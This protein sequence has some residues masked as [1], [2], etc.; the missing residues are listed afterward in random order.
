MA[1]LYP[2]LHDRFRTEG[3]CP[4]CLM[5]TDLAPKYVCDNGHMM[6][7]RCKPYYFSCPTCF[8]PMELQ[9]PPGHVD[10]PHMP[11]QTHYTPLPMPRT[12]F[13]H[14]P[15]APPM[16]DFINKERS[17]YPYEPSPDQ[18]LISCSYQSSGCWVKVP[19]HL[20][21]LHESR[22]QFRPHLEVEVLPTDLNHGQ[23]DLIEC[24]YKAA[25]CNVRTPFWR[26]A[27]H[28]E[29]CVFKDKSI[30]LNEITEDLGKFNFL[31]ESSQLQELVICRYRNYGC[32]VKMPQWRKQIHEAKCNYKENHEEES[33]ADSNAGYDE[34]QLVDCKWA[35]YGCRVMPK[36]Y[37]TKIH[38]RKCNY[39]QDGIDSDSSEEQF[40]PDEQVDC[41]WATYGCN[42]R[43]KRYRKDV[44]EQKC[45]Y[46]PENA[47]SDSSDAENDPEEQVDC[48]W[49]VNGCR[50]R[51]KRLRKA[52]HEEKCNYRMEECVY[53]HNGC[54]ALFTPSRKY[55]H[56]RSCEFTY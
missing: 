34:N 53:K 1:G 22:C 10:S 36:L 5:E 20:Q 8:S 15:S 2:N 55:A 16:N 31:P 25:G 3:I 13:Q 7:Y 41:R 39:R 14:N 43:P 28:E 33:D 37:R 40:D 19:K 23:D 21:Q 12:Q 56:E 42:V 11:P 51:P 6:C 17:S 4:I 49:Y 54:N 35:V 47:G 32:M 29:N 50:V 52:I 45:N 26:Q 48:K 38:E 46:R 18:D 9:H 27:I 24:Q 44:H 30:A